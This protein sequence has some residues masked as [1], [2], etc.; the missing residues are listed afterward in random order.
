MTLYVDAILVEGTQ[1]RKILQHL[2]FNKPILR[3]AK[4]LHNDLVEF[5]AAKFS[6]VVILTDFDEEGTFLNKRLS[7][8]LEEKGVRIDR[9]YRKRIFKLLRS[10]NIF[11]I[12]GI[13][14]LKKSV[15]E[16]L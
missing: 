15:I 11:T 13:D 1:D 2:G 16:R 10:V 14:N 6:V 3:C 9:F 4:Q 12:E 7:K 8:L 5:I